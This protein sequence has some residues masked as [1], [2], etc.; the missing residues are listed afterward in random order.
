M[1]IQ[2]RDKTKSEK[3]YEMINKELEPKEKCITKEK[4]NVLELQDLLNIQDGSN[5]SL[6]IFL[7]IVRRDKTT[8]GVVREI[9]YD[10]YEE[11]A[12]KEMEKM[13]KEALKNFKANDILIKHRMGR[14]AVGEV[15]FVVA[16]L[17]PHRKE[18]INAVD[19]LVDELKRKVPIWK[20]EIFE[21]NSY[22][23]K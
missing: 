11:M 22:R 6:F 19:H 2:T 9:I 10:T 8:K 18:G 23:W 15:S 20:R 17:S 5:G 13:K 21:D 4:I 14:I 12:E 3:N 1:N 16:V 7:G